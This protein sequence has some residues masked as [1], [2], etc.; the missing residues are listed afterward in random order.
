MQ[1]VKSFFFMKK[2]FSINY[3]SYFVKVIRI[4]LPWKV[5][6]AEYTLKKAG[7][8]N[9]KPVYLFACEFHLGQTKK[10]FLRL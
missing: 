5:E 7:K 8:N 1:I 10:R 9:L 4:Y 6:P 2:L 3:D